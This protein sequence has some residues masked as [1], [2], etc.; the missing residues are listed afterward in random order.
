MKRNAAVQGLQV[1]PNLAQTLL[2]FRIHAESGGSLGGWFQLVDQ[3]GRTFWQKDLDGSQRGTHSL[4]LS[5]LGLEGGIYWL[6]WQN[7]D[8]VVSKRMVIQP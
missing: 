2:L 5:E 1:W 6:S 7:E 4:D 8:G 3:W